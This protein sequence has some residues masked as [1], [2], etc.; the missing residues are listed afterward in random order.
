VTLT[1]YNNPASEE[2]L[3]MGKS[4]RNANK[5]WTTTDIQKLAQ[6]A[7]KDTPTDKIA[8]ELGRTEAAIYSEASK[9]QISLMPMDKNK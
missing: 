7:K 8:K 5:I 6:L 4:T 9:K 3:N 1:C 2:V